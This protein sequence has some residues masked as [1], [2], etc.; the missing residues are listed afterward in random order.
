M[1][2][3]DPSRQE[4]I[5]KLLDRLGEFRSEERRRAG[6]G[7]GA[8]TGPR[9]VRVRLDMDERERADRLG[10]GRAYLLEGGSEI[11]VCC[12]FRKAQRDRF[13]EGFGILRAVIEA[14]A[15]VAVVREP[16]H[17]LQ[18]RIVARLAPRPAGG[19]TG[20]AVP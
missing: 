2:D 12:I 15:D 4:R 3:E 16:P 5:R 1:S 6:S 7:P 9:Q 11:E 19:P 13:D 14:L 20:A 10:R 8:S 17:P 18:G